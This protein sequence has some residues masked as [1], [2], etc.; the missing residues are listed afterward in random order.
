MSPTTMYVHYNRLARIAAEIER[1][2]ALEQ[3]RVMRGNHE[4][5]CGRKA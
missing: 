2:A 3:A 4:K 1:D 5:W